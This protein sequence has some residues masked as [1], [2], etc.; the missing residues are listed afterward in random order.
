V[1]GMKQSYE[2]FS[3]Q[4]VSTET[5]PSKMPP[6]SHSLTMWAGLPTQTYFSHPS[7]TRRHAVPSRDL[8][9]SDCTA[10]VSTACEK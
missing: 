2:L 5:D 6:C 3:A 10:V 7:K 4:A 9:T 1:A 8:I